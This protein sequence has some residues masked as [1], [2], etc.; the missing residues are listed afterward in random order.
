[1][2]LDIGGDVG[3]LAGQIKEALV[4]NKGEQAEEYREA[5]RDMIGALEKIEKQDRW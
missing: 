4:L 3:L 2:G 1:M 5:L